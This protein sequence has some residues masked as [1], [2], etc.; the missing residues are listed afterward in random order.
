MAQMKREQ[1]I[2]AITS[3]FRSFL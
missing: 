2:T 1:S 3:Q